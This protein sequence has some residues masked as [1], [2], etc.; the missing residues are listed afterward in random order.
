MIE[1]IVGFI[2]GISLGF[3]LGFYL[4]QLIQ[5]TKDIFDRDPEPVSRVV[6]P[7][8]PGYADVNAQSA[9]ISPK[10]PQQIE[11]EEQER[12]RSL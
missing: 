2:L 9:F 5:K 1:L 12:V 10:T 3:H 4:K 8:Q 6:T 11:R 7:L